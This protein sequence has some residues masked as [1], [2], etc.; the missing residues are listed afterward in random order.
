MALNGLQKCKRDTKWRGKGFENLKP[1]WTSLITKP[2]L[3]AA[4]LQ[5][6]RF[7]QIGDGPLLIPMWKSKL[8][9]H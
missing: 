7:G 2:S 6:L 4:K 9:W 5:N 8:M 1:Y 3:W